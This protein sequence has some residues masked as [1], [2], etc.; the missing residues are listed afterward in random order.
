MEVYP[1]NENMRAAWLTAAI[2]LREQS[3][4]GYA[5]DKRAEK[6]EQVG[7]L[8]HRS[9]VPVVPIVTVT[10]LPDHQ[11]VPP[12]VSEGPWRKAK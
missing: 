5:L 2:W 12:N 8:R 7:V 6:K 3:K 1:H 4:V 11:V 10:S 9:E